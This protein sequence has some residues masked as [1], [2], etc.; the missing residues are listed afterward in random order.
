MMGIN[1]A[2]GNER[3]VDAVGVITVKTF[4][5]QAI[6]AKPIDRLSGRGSAAVQMLGQFLCGIGTV[7]LSVLVF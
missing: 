1:R 7:E 4:A 6:K 2:A 5:D 3:I